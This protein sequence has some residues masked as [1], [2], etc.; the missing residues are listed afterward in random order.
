MKKYLL[1]GLIGLSVTAVK[2]QDISDALR[3]SQ[4]NLNGTARFRAMS[5]AFGALGGDLSSLN[6]NPAGSAIFNNNQVTFTISNYNTKNKSN[7]F[8]TTTSANDNSFDLNQIGG[9][10]VF[11]NNNPESSWRKLTLAVNYENTNNFDNS[12]YSAGTNPTTSIGQYFV[13]QA[14]GVPLDYLVT[15]PG[16][17][18]GGLYS[19][20]GAF[21]GNYQNAFLGYDSFI[22]EPNSTNPQ[23]TLYTSNVVPGG[24]Y[25]QANYINS[26]GYNGKVSFNAAAQY[27]DW[28]SLGLNLNTHFSD[29]TST[30]DFYENNNNAAVP[31]GTNVRNIRFRNELYTYGNGFSFQVG[32]IAKVTNAI[33]FGLAYESPTWMKLNDK[34]RQSLV[35]Y[36]DGSG[37]PAIFDEGITNVY[38]SYRVQTPSKYTGS[39]AYIF[40]SNGLISIDYALKSYSDTKLKPSNDPTFQEYNS[41]MKNI[42]DVTSE[43]RVGAE[44][45]IQNFSLRGGYRFE[46]SPYKNGNT[47]GDL[48]GFSGGLGYNFGATKLDLAY[49]YAKRD[50]DQQMFNTGLTDSSRIKSVNNNVS[51][52]LTFDF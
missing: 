45:R 21:G 14:N 38:P 48:Q 15:R 51:L 49:S 17:T 16:E 31:G 32:A 44:Y 27:Q 8:G 19:Y 5:G 42:L 28:L 1:L 26:S 46:Q 40:G 6:V 34:L 35:A 9:V 50:Y 43:V 52:G 29:Y 22:L 24:N 37:I 3:Y 4:T 39:F 11:N 10:F 12:L 25:S 18:A 30:T 47:I 2:A 20:L 33:R 7:Y 36:R 41:I 23:N 13:N